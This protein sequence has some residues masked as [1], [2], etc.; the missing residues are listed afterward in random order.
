MRAP[1]F[2]PPPLRQLRLHTR[3]DRPGAADHP[4]PQEPARRRRD[5]GNAEGQGCEP[6]TG[7]RHRVQGRER[8][9]RHQGLLPERELHPRGRRRVLHRP[10]CAPH[11]RVQADPRRTGR[12]RADQRNPEGG[13][14]GRRQADRGD[15]EK[16]AGLQPEGVPGPPVQVPLDPARRAQDGSRTRIRHDFEDPVREDVRRTLGPARHLHR[17]LPRPPRID[18]PAER[19]ARPRRPVRADEGLLPNR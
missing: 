3:T 1:A 2:H 15:Q 13:G 18:T 9:N 7:A 10:Q 6:D 16:A 19:S 17:R 14:L 12:V 5:L 4:R 11:R 8:R